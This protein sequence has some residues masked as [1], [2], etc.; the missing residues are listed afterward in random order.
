MSITKTLLFYKVH[1]LVNEWLGRKAQVSVKCL[2]Q[3]HNTQALTSFEFTTMVSRGQTALG[4]PHG[5]QIW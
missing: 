5:Y 4:M 3:G 1:S 2:A